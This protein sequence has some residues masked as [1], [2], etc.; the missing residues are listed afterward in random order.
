MSD[1]C[2]LLMRNLMSYISATT[3]LQFND[4]DLEYLETLNMSV[5]LRLE[6][7]LGNRFQ[8]ISLPVFLMNEGND[9]NAYPVRV[10]TIVTHANHSD[11]AEAIANQIAELALENESLTLFVHSAVLPGGIKESTP[12][13]LDRTRWRSRYLVK[14][15]TLAVPKQN[16]AVPVQEYIFRSGSPTPGLNLDFNQVMEGTSPIED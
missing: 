15:G 2:Q 16:Q 8:A 14:R 3:E 12:S 7:M 13:K 5:I 1:K 10:E 4:A 6:G 9:I 11:R